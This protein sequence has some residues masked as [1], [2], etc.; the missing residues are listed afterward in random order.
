MNQRLILHKVQYY[1]A[2][3]FAFISPE[4][5]ELHCVGWRETMSAVSFSLILCDYIENQMNKK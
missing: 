1:M 2:N 5:G 4:F 3:D